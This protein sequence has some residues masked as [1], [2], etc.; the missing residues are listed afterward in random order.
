MCSR[1]SSVEDGCVPRP[2]TYNDC[3]LRRVLFRW[4]MRFTSYEQTQSELVE[5]TIRETLQM[6]PD[7]SDD[8]TIDVALLATMR[9]IAL[10]EFGIAHSHAHGRS[11][12]DDSSHQNDDQ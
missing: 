3:L 2:S 5:R 12:S 11:L 7:V 1:L 8:L 6:F 9:R 10:K 4:A